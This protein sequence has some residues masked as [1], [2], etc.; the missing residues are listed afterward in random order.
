MKRVREN[1]KLS[2]IFIVICALSV[3]L[4]A[5]ISTGVQAD[6]PEV[7]D[8]QTIEGHISEINSEEYYLF[9]VVFSSN[10]QSKTAHCAASTSVTD[11]S[12]QEELTVGTK[13]LAVVDMDTLTGTVFD[14]VETYVPDPDPVPEPEPEPEPAV[15]LPDGMELVSCDPTPDPEHVA[16]TG[17]VKLTV[18]IHPGDVEGI[19]TNI[20]PGVYYVDKGL[21]VLYTC[22]SENPDWE[23]A[24]W[25]IGM[26]VSGSLKKSGVGYE[27]YLRLTMDTDIVLMAFHRERI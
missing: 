7:E 16:P 2:T 19:S 15:E 21:K 22:K 9:D 6:I 17:C 8:L 13:V 23:F 27:H 3:G 14:S 20:P 1:H 25:N 24:Y 18:L 5:N 4:F 10:G 26:G 11:L 12:E